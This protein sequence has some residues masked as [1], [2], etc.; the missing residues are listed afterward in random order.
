MGVTDKNYNPWKK[1]RDC[2]PPPGAGP[3]FEE[4][5]GIMRRNWEIQKRVNKQGERTTVV[6]EEVRYAFAPRYQTVEGTVGKYAGNR[7]TQHG[8]LILLKWGT[9][10][11]EA[12]YERHWLADL[13]AVY[14][15]QNGDPADMK[16]R[17]EG[18]NIRKEDPFAPRRI[19]KAVKKQVHLPEVGSRISHRMFGLGTI[20]K[21]EGVREQWY[22]LVQFDEDFD[23]TVGP[24]RPREFGSAAFNG[25]TITSG[26]PK[27]VVQLE[28]RTVGRDPSTLDER[29]DMNPGQASKAMTERTAQGSR[30]AYDVV[31]RKQPKART[32]G[33]EP[34]LFRRSANRPKKQ[35]KAKN[36]ITK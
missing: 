36:Y 5:R 15:D 10:R 4:V 11:D 31:L 30:D 21:L 3:Q 9:K 22:A 35:D 16:W 23:G 33:A 1:M 13:Q 7:L 12:V 18:H 28:A 24:I 32:Q 34:K 25:V 2:D 29:V 6:K 20:A 26:L 27:P 14:T 17:E 8:W 19:I